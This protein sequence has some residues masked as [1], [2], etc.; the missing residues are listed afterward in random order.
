LLLFCFFQKKGWTYDSKANTFQI[1]SINT[2]Q[3]GDE[4]F[5]VFGTKCNSEL[6]DF[7]GQFNANNTDDCVHVDVELSSTDPL[8]KEKRILYTTWNPE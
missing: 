3:P 6:V 2:Y 5:L 1:M 8:A 7:Y 4:V